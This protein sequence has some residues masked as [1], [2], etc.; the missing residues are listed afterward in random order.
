MQITLAA[1]NE[2]GRQRWV[3]R[4]IGRKQGVPLFLLL[5]TR[6]LG[7]PRSPHLI[8]DFKRFTGNAQCRARRR[9]FVLTQR[10]TM[11]IVAT[12]LVWRAFADN[13]L[14]ANERRLGVLRL[15]SANGRIDGIDIVTIDAADNIPA[16]GFKTLRRIVGKPAD[17][18]AIDG[19]AVIVVKGYQLGQF[20]DPG[21]RAHLMRNAFHHAAVAH[22]GIAVVIDN[23][24]TLTIELGR[25]QLLG[26]R[27]A[28]GVTDALPKWPRRRLDAGR[29]AVFWVTGGLAAQLAEF[30]ELIEW[31]IVTGE[32]E[33]RVEQHRTVTVG[34][35]ETVAV[36]PFRIGRVVLEM[37]VPQGDGHFSH[38][39]RC[40]RVAGICRLHTIHGQH[41][42]SVG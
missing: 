41:A 42:D 34:K 39:H 18:I 37:P 13:R 30:L 33:Q 24:E 11:H 36:S 32:V 16:I 1:T 29:M 8:G 2:L 15:G 21:Q 7:V 35:Y 5:G 27:K 28:N 9:H 20:P 12:G 14:A 10:R 26:Q 22:E 23:R 40:A 38:P 3:S 6:C 31:Q 19:N 4:A 25:Q 17:D